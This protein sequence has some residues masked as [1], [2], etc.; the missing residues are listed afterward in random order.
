M[1]IITRQSL[2]DE[3]ADRWERQYGDFKHYPNQKEISR[4]LKALKRPVIPDDVDR[5]IGNT[6]WTTP[7]ACSICKKYSGPV[8]E[9]GDEPDYDSSTAWLCF[10]CVRKVAKIAQDFEK[11]E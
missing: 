7:C 10:D 2:A 6:S 5:L 1:K 11:K 9:V 4:K 3:A 8:I